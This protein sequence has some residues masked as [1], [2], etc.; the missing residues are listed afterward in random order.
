MVVTDKNCEDR[1]NGAAGKSNRKS[2]DNRILGAWQSV[3]FSLGK[4]ER[5]RE[6]LS[7][8]ASLW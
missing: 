2:G 7:P 4:R 3:L 6:F 1:A 8:G 5:E